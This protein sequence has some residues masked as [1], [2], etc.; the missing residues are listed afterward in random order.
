MGAFVVN[1]GL[2]PAQYWALTL[3]ERDAIVAAWNRRQQ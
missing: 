3:R 1:F 2:T